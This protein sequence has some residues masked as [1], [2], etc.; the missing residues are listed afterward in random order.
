MT[1][2]K[3]EKSEKTIQKEMKKEKAK[4]KNATTKDLLEYIINL[5]EGGK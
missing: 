3:I 4:S 5:L 1:K 2:I